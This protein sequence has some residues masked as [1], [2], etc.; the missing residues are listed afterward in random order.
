LLIEKY[1]ADTVFSAVYFDGEQQYFYLK[2]FKFE[3]SYAPQ[4][5][6]DEHHDSYLV[7]ISQ[8]EFPQIEVRFKG[9]HEKRVAEFVDVDEFIG[10]K[11][12][13]AKGKRIS[14]FDVG[15]VKFIEPLEKT[16]KP[17][18]ENS[19]GIIKNDDANAVQMSLL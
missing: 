18:E 15:E 3:Q 11:S 5:F 19:N 14:T 13:R 12:S 10:I 7:E 16:Q 4:R 1:N 9:K 8:D 6:I 17:S 2:R